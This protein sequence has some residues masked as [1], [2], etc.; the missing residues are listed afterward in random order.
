[1]LKY[2]EAV[3]KDLLQTAAAECAGMQGKHF[4]AA[5]QVVREAIYTRP[6]VAAA[7]YVPLAAT[8]WLSWRCKAAAAEC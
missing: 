7:P 8:D 5:G 2:A 3:L 4:A 1:M 6:D